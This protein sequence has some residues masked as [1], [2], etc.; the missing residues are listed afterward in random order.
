MRRAEELRTWIGGWRDLEQRADALA[1][2]AQM[3]SDDPE[4][5]S[6]R[7]REALDHRAHSASTEPAVPIGLNRPTVR[8]VARR[9][10]A[11]A[12]AT[13]SSVTPAIESHM[14]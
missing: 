1:E 10:D 6:A 13:D 2:M 11:A 8:F 5:A 4:G 3:A 12:R 14:W 9:Q 7:R